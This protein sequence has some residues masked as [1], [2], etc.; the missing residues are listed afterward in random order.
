MFGGGKLS[1]MGQKPIIL[2]NTHIGVNPIWTNYLEPDSLTVKFSGILKGSAWTYGMTEPTNGT[3]VLNW[4]TQGEWHINTGDSHP[5]IGC[6][7][8]D[9]ALVIFNF[10]FPPMFHS[11][12]AAL[13]NM[14]MPNLL[15]D[16]TAAYYGGQAEFELPLVGYSM[17]KEWAAA[18]LFQ[19]PE[20]KNSF[21]NKNDHVGGGKWFQYNAIR[22]NSQVNIITN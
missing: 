18:Q 10:A 12:Q 20:Y 3:W 22:T 19:V 6:H 1:S 5:R 16:S 2:P 8:A 9:L 4:W 11:V 13:K 7:S 21:G 14:I 15:V 17:A